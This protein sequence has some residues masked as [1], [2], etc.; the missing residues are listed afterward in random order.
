MG[1]CYTT[2]CEGFPPFR[3]DEFNTRDEAIKFIENLSQQ[4][5]LSVLMVNHLLR[6]YLMLIIVRN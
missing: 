4:H 2:N 1:C 6:H 5:L 3:V